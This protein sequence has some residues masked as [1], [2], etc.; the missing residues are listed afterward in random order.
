[1][2]EHMVCR[3]KAHPDGDEGEG[4][5]EIEVDGTNG[6]FTGDSGDIGSARVRAGCAGKEGMSEAGMAWRSSAERWIYATASLGG[7]RRARVRV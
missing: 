5:D 7:G 1:M 4:Q 2:V 6:A 3:E